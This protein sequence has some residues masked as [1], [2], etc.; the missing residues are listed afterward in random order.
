MNW[1]PAAWRFVDDEEAN[2]WR[3]EPAREGYELPS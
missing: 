3:S 1:D 2:G